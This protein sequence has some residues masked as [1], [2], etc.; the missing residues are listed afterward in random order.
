[1]V[2]RSF[3]PTEY[4]PDPSE[5]R[6]ENERAAR[7]EQ[8]RDDERRRSQE[9]EDTRRRLREV[10]NDPEI[11]IDTEMM[12]SINDREQV[13]TENGDIARITRRGRFQ[14]QFSRGMGYTLPV[15]KKRRKSN[16]RRNKNLSIAF[17]KANEKL[18]LK[19]GNLRKGK[20]QSDIAR[21]A[22]RLLKKM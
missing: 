5:R 21:L 20:T 2:E 6:R 7:E 22:H 3:D 13:M 1:M 8:R 19:N 4:G 9:R 10:V 18:R 17:K 15:K 12:K 11:S 14:D 16:K